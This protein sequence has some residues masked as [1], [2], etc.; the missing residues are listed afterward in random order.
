M[1]YTL[2]NIYYYLKRCR[3]GLP[4]GRRRLEAGDHHWRNL[5]GGQGGTAKPCPKAC[6]YFSRCFFLL[7]WRSPVFFFRSVFLAGTRR[8][9]R[10]KSL[11][12]N[13]W[14]SGTCPRLP[15]TVAFSSVSVLVDTCLSRL[16]LV[17]VPSLRV[18]QISWRNGRGR[19]CHAGARSMDG[20]RRCLSLH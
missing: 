20:T 19:H 17:T 14:L 5:R 1:P 6:L 10:R 9:R 2:L 4:P 8:R 3:I 7:L 15:Q 13:H 12:V 18:G 16:V 11:A